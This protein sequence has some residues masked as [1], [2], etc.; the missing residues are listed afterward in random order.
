MVNGTM[1]GKK[2]WITEVAHGIQAIVGPPAD[3]PNLSF[4]DLNNWKPH[5][6][7]AGSSFFGK[8]QY[9]ILGGNR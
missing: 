1:L 7:I 2:D 9:F 3:N 5:F 4:H 8:N 6:L